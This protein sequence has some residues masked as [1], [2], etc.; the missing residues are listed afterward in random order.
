[1]TKHGFYSIVQKSPGEFHVRARV[2]DDLKNLLRR[3]PLPELKIHSSAVTDYSYR[4]IVNHE[5]MLFILRFLGE[6]LDYSNFKDMIHDNPD[7]RGKSDVYGKIW[8][9]LFDEFGG[10][11]QKPKSPA[12]KRQ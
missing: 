12:Q 9:N 4:I 2:E 10:Y 7:Q 8:L 6:S 11:G 3:V 5:Q 1:M